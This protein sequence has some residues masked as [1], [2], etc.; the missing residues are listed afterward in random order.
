M[1]RPSSLAAAAG[2]RDVQGWE[3]QVERPSLHLRFDLSETGSDTAHPH[4]YRPQPAPYV[5]HGPVWLVVPLA[6]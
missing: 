6:E 2:L 1:P 3:T 4:V 5:V